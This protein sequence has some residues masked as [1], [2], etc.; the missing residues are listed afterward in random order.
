MPRRTPKG[1]GAL[2]ASLGRVAQTLGYNGRAIQR[3]LKVS[4]YQALQIKHAAQERQPIKKWIG[5]GAQ[6][7]RKY[8]R[9]QASLEKSGW[10]FRE[11][12]FEGKKRLAA[13]PPEPTK[14]RRAKKQSEKKF[15]NATKKSYKYQPHRKIEI[16]EGAAIQIIAKGKGK[17]KGKDIKKLASNVGGNWEGAWASF[18]EMQR[19]TGFVAREI[20][21]IVIQA[22]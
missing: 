18:N 14:G 8:D 19:R 2:S 17:S 21:I 1:A 20:Q 13:I 11:Q 15:E 7:Q 6:G 9:L 16:P 10:R 3:E 5:E 22:K 4:Y 12:R